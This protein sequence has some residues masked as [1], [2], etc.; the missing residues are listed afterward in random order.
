M[1]LPTK[2]EVEAL[3]YA[4]KGGPR[5]Q[6]GATR[7]VAT[8]ALDYARP[9]GPSAVGSPSTPE[10]AFPCGS[11]PHA[12]ISVYMRSDGAV[13]SRY[14][15]ETKQ[16]AQAVF[17][18]IGGINDF[19]L[20]FWVRRPEIP[21]RSSGVLT[22]IKSGDNR[23]TVAVANDQTLQVS[24]TD[25]TTT[26][27]RTVTPPLVGF[28]WASVTLSHDTLSGLL[29]V[30]GGTQ[31]QPAVW[32]VTMDLSGLTHAPAPGTSTTIFDDAEGSQPIDADVIAWGLY[33]QGIAEVTG[34]GL[35]EE[36]ERYD[37]RNAL[38]DPDYLY[39]EQAEDGA[40][41]NAGCVGG[42]EG[43]V[44]V[45][46]GGAG[47]ETDFPK[48]GS[49]FGVL[50][51]GRDYS[52]EGG[53]EINIRRVQG[54]WPIRGPYRI[55]LL[56]SDDLKVY[57]L[58]R[59]GCF[60]CE[61]GLFMDCYADADRR[62]IRFALPS[63]PSQGYGV[64][65]SHSNG[66]VVASVGFL[67][68]VMPRNRAWPEAYSIGKNIGAYS[69]VAGPLVVTDEQEATDA[70]RP[71][72]V[73]W[74]ALVKA[75]GRALREV[76]GA[77][78][79]RLRGDHEAGDEVLGL[80]TTLAIPEEGWFWLDGRLIE[81]KSRDAG[82]REITLVEPLEEGAPGNTPVVLDLKSLAHPGLYREP[83][84]IPAEVEG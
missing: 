4:G 68:T 27:S 30:R 38:V 73:P 42:G 20:R 60:S 46:E 70:N 36:G 31:E 72:Y 55:Q 23:V 49:A 24:V 12:A 34:A 14:R 45:P 78:T 11:E 56:G 80:E 39:R 33:G 8:G 35:D 82:D 16:V 26:V 84:R 47:E 13:G 65:I 61:P 48:G 43:A 75:F 37:T 67:L 81:Y 32:G 52:D 21:V 51:E 50:G 53:Y 29:N 28:D 5:A 25:G 62:R 40:V 71:P 41:P 10:T 74:E 64:R 76:S 69:E 7:S 66:T 58:G 2:S 59:E 44:L 9:G 83:R 22:Q 18:E 77:P 79:T 63:L 19:A 1:A 57:P 17:P 3:D 54:Q 6:V 15:G